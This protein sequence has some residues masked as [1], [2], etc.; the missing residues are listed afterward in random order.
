MLNEPF[1]LGN[2]KIPNRVLLAPL[3]GVSDAPFRRICTEL[4]AGLTYIE[5][6]SAAGMPHKNRKSGELIYRAPEEEILGAQMT[7]AAPEIMARGAEILMEKDL[8]IDTLDINMGCPV[9]KI[10][11]RGCGSAIV[12]DPK[13]A[14]EILQATIEAVDIPVTTKIRL[15]FT[16]KDQTVEAVCAELSKVGTE[17][18]VI[19]GRTRD[20]GYSDPVQYDRIKDGFAAAK[21]VSR[22]RPLWTIG[23]GNIFDFA[24]ARKMVELTGC[25]GVMISRGCLGNPW[26]F[27][28]ILQEHARQPAVA[29]WLKVVLRHVDYHTAFYGE[30]HYAAI[31]FRKHL[32][33]YV[34][35]YPGSR[36]LRSEI[37]QLNLMADIQNRL[38]EYSETLPPDL[39]RYA[40]QQTQVK[41][42][43]Y[44][45]KNE[46]DRDHDRGVEH[47]ESH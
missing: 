45:P 14:G 27:D 18:L 35:G 33:W 4:G 46:M 34:S 22:D 39:V 28:Q 30:G 29:D 31:R 10:V 40:D 20:C 13:L 24:S 6:L 19:H 3:A 1:Y 41:A 44:D 42:G 12:K 15:G 9:K 21:D 17:M 26:I 36:S 32:L 8:Q 16:K 23:N 37:G 7:G 25:D 47:Y 43:D 5:M 38:I 11:G 2:L